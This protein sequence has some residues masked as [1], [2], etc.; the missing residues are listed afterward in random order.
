M[1][2]GI[3]EVIG[4][5]VAIFSLMHIA[6]LVEFSIHLNAPRPNDC[7]KEQTMQPEPQPINLERLKREAKALKRTQP[8]T[9]S[10][11]LDLLARRAGYANYTLLLRDLK[12]KG[13][14]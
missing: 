14:A 5:C 4:W 3:A 11:A 8:V 12:A 2:R 9:H 13:L 7:H 6:N 1:I 10:Q